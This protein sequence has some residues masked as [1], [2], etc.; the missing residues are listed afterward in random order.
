MGRSQTWR[1]NRLDVSLDG[2]T[3]A[4]L[5]WRSRCRGKKGRAAKMRGLF[6]EA[7]QRWGISRHAHDLHLVAKDSELGQISI[8]RQHPRYGFDDNDARW[9]FMLVPLQI[10]HRLARP[11][12]TRLDRGAALR[13]TARQI[14]SLRLDHA[15]D[16]GTRRDRHR[17]KNARGGKQPDQNPP[18]TALSGHLSGLLFAYLKGRDIR[19]G[20][21]QCRRYNDRV[22]AETCDR[23]YERRDQ[24]PRRRGDCDRHPVIGGF[25]RRIPTERRIGGAPRRQAVNLSADNSFEEI[26]RTARQLE[27]P[28]HETI[29]LQ[30]ELDFGSAQYFCQ[31]GRNEGIDMP[32]DDVNRS[33]SR[34]QSFP[35][36][37]PLQHETAVLLL[38][39]LVETP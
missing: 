11:V 39:E 17:A 10:K 36:R 25:G 6:D 32:I 3:L 38:D 9:R 31:F 15:A 16:D 37:G 7:N 29:G 2:E 26:R 20:L 22:G 18:D 34:V 13:D 4:R 19:P 12:V 28:E 1:V 5:R 27:Q 33:P 23:A 30:H 14:I 35:W 21:L 8:V 24:R